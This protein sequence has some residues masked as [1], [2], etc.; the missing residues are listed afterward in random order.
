MKDES[1]L[2]VHDYKPRRHEYAALLKFFH[3]PEET[4]KRKA[5]G[6]LLQKANISQAI[7]SYRHE[8]Y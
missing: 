8:M 4:K 3:A 6:I 1:F 7:D 2:F 5:M